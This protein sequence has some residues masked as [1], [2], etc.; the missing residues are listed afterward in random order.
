MS[1]SV[2]FNF[3]AAQLPVKKEILPIGEGFLPKDFLTELSDSRVM[4]KIDM[5]VDH[6]RKSIIREARKTRSEAPF[7]SKPAYILNPKHRHLDEK[8]LVALLSDSETLFSP[9][10][11]QYRTDHQ[12]YLKYGEL[13]GKT[14][15]EQIIFCRE[16]AL[17]SVPGHLKEQVVQFLIEFQELMTEKRWSAQTAEENFIS[18][19]VRREL[20]KDEI[21]RF[22]LWCIG[23]LCVEQTGEQTTLDEQLRKDFPEIKIALTESK[24]LYQ[25]LFELIQNNPDSFRNEYRRILAFFHS[26]PQAKKVLER[27]IPGIRIHE[28][29][30]LD[31]ML[32]LSLYLFHCK[33]ILT[34]K[35][36]RGHYRRTYRKCDENN[37]NSYMRRQ[38]ILSDVVG[39]YKSWSKEDLDSAFFNLFEFSV[40]SS[41]SKLSKIKMQEGM[42]TLCKL[43]KTYLSNSGH[44]VQNF[45]EEYAQ[46]VIR[47]VYHTGSE[48]LSH[49]DR[50]KTFPFRYMMVCIAGTSRLYSSAVTITEEDI[51]AVIKKP[52]FAKPSN[53]TQ[54][55]ERI[56]FLNKLNQICCL[57]REDKSKNWKYFL[58]VHGAAIE[59]PAEWDLW[60]EI[61]YGYGRDDEKET[62]EDIPPIE[63]T[64]LCSEFLR[65][66]LPVQYQ[67]LYCYE[68][69]QYPHLGG[70][71]K[72]LHKYSEG[73]RCC[74]QRIKTNNKKWDD[75]VKAYM[76][77]GSAHTYDIMSIQKLCEKISNKIRWKSIPGASES[78]LRDFCRK[79]HSDDNSADQAITKEVANMRILLV[80]AAF[81]HILAE[82]AEKLLRKHIIDVFNSNRD[83]SICLL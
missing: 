50:I 5:A 80:E 4:C 64:L 56:R 1:S 70:F 41:V 69:G 23:N 55:I 15:E 79:A 81:R 16:R 37:Y 71:A 60:K 43:T 67:F 48:Q 42:S 22:A 13:Q 36:E 11:Q 18:E 28:D 49:K 52:Y 82:N 66:C 59:S 33:D 29:S 7:I 30:M 9:N 12:F 62:Y 75:P 83:F 6:F 61:I 45:N 24:I 25:D 54:R 65:S 14:K 78:D 38:E 63:L 21:R 39:R 73:L 68:G 2:H 19:V 44:N 17:A 74:I 27:W 72:F 8:E 46:C 34:V 32:A 57:D 76:K 77:Y 58:Q 31:F 53:K 26:Y 47:S 40:D 10:Y 35:K 20:S 3:D 51:S